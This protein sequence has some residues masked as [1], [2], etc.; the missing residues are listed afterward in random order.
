MK[1]LWLNCLDALGDVLEANGQDDEIDAVIESSQ[2]LD[3][4]GV[5][6]TLVEAEK[7][8]NKRLLLLIDNIDLVFDRLKKDHSHLR[9]IL[10]SEPQIQFI[11]ASAR[12]VEATYDYDAAFYK[13]LESS[14]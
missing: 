6:A 8:Y 3:A 13:F 1:Y 2:G 14:S 11:G 10:Q 5:L 9:E 7:R 12:A 4:D